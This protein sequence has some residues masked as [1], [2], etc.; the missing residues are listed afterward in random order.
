M[1]ASMKPVRLLLPLLLA[2]GTALAD[3]SR[4]ELRDAPGRDLVVANCRLCHSLDYIQMNSLFLERRGWEAS[5]NKMINVMG[6]PIKAED[7]PSI[8]DY[9]NRAYGK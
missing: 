2:T 6:A 5:V 4:I 9:L 7:V 3:E 8:V 1:R